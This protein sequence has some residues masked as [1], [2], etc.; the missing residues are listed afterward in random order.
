MINF[1]LLFDQKKRNLKMAN[2]LLTVALRNAL[3][4]PMGS[5]QIHHL[6]KIGKREVVGYGWNGST[7]YFDRVDYPFPAVRFREVTP[8]IMVKIFHF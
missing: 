1:D 8:D 2:R 3:K 5:S 4:A 7:I 6:H